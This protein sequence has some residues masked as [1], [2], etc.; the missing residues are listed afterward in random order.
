MAI[1]NLDENEHIDLLQIQGVNYKAGDVPPAIAEQILN[2]KTSFLSRWFGKGVEH[3]RANIIKDYLLI[4]N[5]VVE[6]RYW[7]KSHLQQMIF[8][9]S[10][11]INEEYENNL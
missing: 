2:I 5:E 8:Y 6:M 1:I 7:T 9:L 11:R 10:K 3:Q 4:K